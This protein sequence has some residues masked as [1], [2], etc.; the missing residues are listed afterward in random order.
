MIKLKGDYSKRKEEILSNVNS[1]VNDRVTEGID[2][3]RWDRLRDSDCYI[4]EGV[5]VDIGVDMDILE[6]Y[7]KGKIRLMEDRYRDLYSRL[8]SKVESYEGMLGSI[9]DRV[10]IQ[11]DSLVKG[12]EGLRAL[13]EDIKDVINNLIDR[14]RDIEIRINLKVEEVLNIVK[15]YDKH[16]KDFVLRYREVTDSYDILLGKVDTL[17]KRVEGVEK[18]LG[19]VL[20]KGD[21]MV[22]DYVGG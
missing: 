13:K 4:D 7:V 6:S 16:Y 19:K 21:D 5:R 11:D 22:K 9:G 2:V 14:F 3:I 12:F 15:L 20:D 8:V 1:G 10:K 18:M 17:L